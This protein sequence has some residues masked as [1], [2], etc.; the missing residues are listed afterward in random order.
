MGATWHFR[1]YAT[2]LVDEDTNDKP[3]IFVRN[4]SVLAYTGLATITDVNGNDAPEL[5]A[6]RVLDDGNVQVTIKDSVTEDLISSVR[7]PQRRTE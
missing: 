1:S 5:V 3:D 2:N 7:F 6:L 4:R